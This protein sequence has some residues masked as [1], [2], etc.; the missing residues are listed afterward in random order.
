MPQFK[1]L[2]LNDIQEP[3]LPIRAAMDETKMQELCQ[4]LAE[5]GLLQPIG[6]KPNGTGCLH[7]GRDEESHTKRVQCQFYMTYEIEFGH[8]RFI[9][10]SRLQWKEIP[11]LIF[12][13]AELVE[14]AAMLAEN[15]ERE[16][17]TAA[18]EAMLFAQA[19]ERYN[20]DEEGLIKRFRKSASYIGDRLQLL[21]A[22]REV[23]KALHERK[24]NFSVARELNKIDDENYRRYYLDA[25]MRGGA[26][27]RTVASWRQQMIAQQLPATDASP[28]PATTAETPQQVTPQVACFLCGGHLDP[29]NMDSV[30]IHKHEREHIQKLLQQ[31]AEV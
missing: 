23:F 8:R 14:G 15:N 7:C 12:T 28:V 25:A 4:S 21:R 10:A 17:V 20:L 26:N 3:A 5:I 27:A 30:F 18:E 31:A 19:Q 11:A 16:D 1:I 13:T 22:D 29:W 9:A 6:V 24:I 2:Q